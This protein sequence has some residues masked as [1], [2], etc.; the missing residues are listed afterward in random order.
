MKRK[1]RKEVRMKS[2]NLRAL[3]LLK[4]GEVSKSMDMTQDGLNYYSNRIIEAIAP[5][6]VPDAGLIVISLRHIADEVE[7]D[8]EGT[9]EFVEQFSKSLSFPVLLQ[10]ESHRK[11]NAE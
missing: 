10:V 3:D 2:F 8:N 7:K 5:Y 9:K 11:P 4:K 6:A 1:K